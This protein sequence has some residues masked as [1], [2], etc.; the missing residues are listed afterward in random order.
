MKRIICLCF[1]LIFMTLLAGCSRLIEE[2]N[3]ND[4]PGDE[5][6]GSYVF[7]A[8]VI[9]S[10]NR[11]LVAPDK[12]SNEIKSA[13]KIAVGLT[14]GLILGLN[15]ESLSKEELKAGDLVK[16]TYDGIIRESYPAQ[17]TA[18]LIEIT[19]RNILIDG[20]IALI[21]DIYNEDT[22][23]N[24]DITM[25]ALDTSEWTDLT[26][27]DKEIIFQSL[28]ALY[29]LDIIEG[30][31]EELSDQG[32][33]DRDKL[34]FPDGILISIKNI[35]YNEKKKTINCSIEKWRSGLGAI[36]SDDVKAEYKDGQWLITKSAMWIS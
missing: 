5:D 17:I 27:I 9:D 14:D 7:V 31:F 25:I 18:S 12:D 4:S 23:L 33:I 35:N 34:Y 3:I 36:G 10:S 15:G 32:L 16:I 8:Q 13:D 29:E 24:G 21:D 1:M 20:Y 2:G 22:G 19:G 26:D 28:K 30:T 11:L 6:T